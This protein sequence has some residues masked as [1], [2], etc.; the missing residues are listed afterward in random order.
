MSNGVA[1]TDRI[2]QLVQELRPNQP[3][4]LDED[5]R[6][7]GLTSLGTVRLMMDVELAFQIAIPSEELHPD[8]F[9]SVRAVG[10]LV[11]RLGA[12]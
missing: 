10:S 12:S 6:S 8:N 5:L 2:L 11:S 3:I 7:A 4:G 1:V 9:R